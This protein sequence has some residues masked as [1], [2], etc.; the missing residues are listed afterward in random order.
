MRLTCWLSHARKSIQCL[1]SSRSDIFGRRANNRLFSE[2]PAGRKIIN[3]QSY[4]TKRMSASTTA[5]KSPISDSNI[6]WIDMEMTGLDPAKD[7]IMEVACLITNK[8]LEIVAEGPNLTI[9]QPLEKLNAMNEWCLEHHTKSGLFKASLE[10]KISLE[11][12]EDELLK[13][14]QRHTPRGKCPLAGNSVYMDKYFLLKYMPRFCGHL[15]YR[16]LDVSSV[17]ILAKNWYNLDPPNKIFAHRALDDIKESIQEL[18]YYQTSIFKPLE[19][20]SVKSLQ[21]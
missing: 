14:V 20:T 21:K 1:C 5:P 4:T 18:T 8:D 16:I 11:Q 17:K 10:S 15:H 19:S 3:L 13:F 7:S 6:I 9:H 2:H 12:A